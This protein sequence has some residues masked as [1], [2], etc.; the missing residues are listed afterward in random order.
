VAVSEAVAAGGFGFSMLRGAAAERVG[1]SDLE[2]LVN[3]LQ[4]LPRPVEVPQVQR[5]RAER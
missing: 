2:A 5:F 4:R 3:Y 1:V